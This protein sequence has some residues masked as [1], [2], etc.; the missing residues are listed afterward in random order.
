MINEILD[1]LKDNNGPKWQTSLLIQK[2]LIDNNLNHLQIEK[3]LIEFY[4]NNINSVIRY[5]TLPNKRNLEVLWGHIERVGNRKLFDIYREDN[6]IEASYLNDKEDERNIFLSHSFN[7][8]KIVF[9]LASILVKN[10]LNPWIAEVDIIQGYHINNEVISAIQRLPFFGILLT[11]NVLES[12][13][14]AK[15]FEFALKNKRKLYAFIN[16]EEK[17]I[18]DLIKKNIN[19]PTF[20]IHDLLR[21]IFDNSDVTDN[22]EFYLFS[23]KDEKK[24]LI[25]IK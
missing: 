21:K 1:I 9:D 17:E 16:D 4:K 2:K 3:I 13:W 12:T 19:I 11:K 5:S 25:R 24:P 15:E 8:T 6:H 18:V 10:N 20:V 23:L 14:S 7:D 22:M